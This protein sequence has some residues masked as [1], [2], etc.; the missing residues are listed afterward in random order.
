VPT[1]DVLLFRGRGLEATFR[2]PGARFER[3]TLSDLPLVTLRP[4]DPE[5]LFRPLW[6][7]KWRNDDFILLSEAPPARESK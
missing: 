6:T 5:S 1:R 4:D 3:A 2:L 7:L